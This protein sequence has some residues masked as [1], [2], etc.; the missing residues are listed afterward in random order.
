MNNE[1]QRKTLGPLH[2]VYQREMAKF[3]Q[4]IFRYLDEDLRP[5]FFIVGVPRDSRHA[6]CIEPSEDSGYTPPYFAGIVQ[7]AK[8]LE[9]DEAAKNAWKHPSGKRKAAPISSRSLQKAVDKVLNDSK[10]DDKYIS[11]SSEPATIGKYEVFCVLR[12]ERDVLNSHYSVSVQWR[13][14]TRVVRTANRCDG[15]RVSPS[16]SNGSERS[17]T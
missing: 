8:E 3:A 1:E 2:W 14:N 17:E 11:Y 13:D 12:L 5:R 15:H 7:L 10:K 6:V 4:D 16:V 9:A